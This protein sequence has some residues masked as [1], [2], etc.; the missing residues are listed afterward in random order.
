MGKICSYLPDVECEQFRKLAAKN[1][2][3]RYQL[4]NSILK[5]YMRNPQQIRLIIKC[6]KLQKSCAVI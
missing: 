2:M 4:F 3:T 1:G 5:S 6:E